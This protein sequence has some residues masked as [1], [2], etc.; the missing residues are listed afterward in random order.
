V[1]PRG[2]FSVE[3]VARAETAAPMRHALEAFLEA[4]GIPESIRLDAVTAVGEA[5][6]NAVEHAYRGG[7]AGEVKVLACLEGGGVLTV[8]VVDRG[9]FAQ[10]RPHPDR[11]FGLRIVRSVAASVKFETERGTTIKM[12]FDLPS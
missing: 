7:P 8:E 1:I 4:L 6:A 5:L 3:C 10:P 2:Q 12:R 11:G 9:T